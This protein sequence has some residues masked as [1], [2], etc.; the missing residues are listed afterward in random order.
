MVAIISGGVADD[1]S[2]LASHLAGTERSFSPDAVGVGGAIGLISTSRASNLAG[3]GGGLPHAGRGGGT[4]DLSTDGGAGGLADTVLSVP[5][6]ERIR[7]ALHHGGVDVH[8]LAATSVV[9]APGAHGDGLAITLAVNS[10]TVLAAHT[11]ILVPDAASIGVT[12]GGVGV[13]GGTRS[14]AIGADAIPTAGLVVVASSF[15][16]VDV[17]RLRAGVGGRIPLAIGI[18]GTSFL[19]GVT[20][21]AL[22]GALAGGGVE[23][24]ESGSLAIGGDEGRARRSAGLVGVVPQAGGITDATISGGVGVLTAL[25]ALILQRSGLVE[26]AHGVGGTSLG[27]GGDIDGGGELVD[28]TAIASALFGG[29]IPHAAIGTTTSGGVGEA[30]SALHDTDIFGF[31]VAEVGGDTFVTISDDRALL[32]AAAGVGLVEA[33]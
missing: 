33:S 12:V 32:V 9:G 19:T 18:G 24:A 23:G 1:T 17:A 20:G 10:R 5:H 3:S 30:G 26:A 27:E 14:K 21:R 31:E 4:G 7:D 29:L 2:L 8:A 22:V 28:G 15:L 11:R 13:H 6:A 25:G 16:L